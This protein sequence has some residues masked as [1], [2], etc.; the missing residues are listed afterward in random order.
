MD[1]LL[2]SALDK[3]IDAA[4]SVA[5]PGAKAL[6]NLAK[7]AVSWFTSDKEVIENRPAFGDAPDAVMAFVAGLFD[8]AAGAI[9]NPFYKRVVEMARDLVVANVLDRAWDALFGVARAAD[10][11]GTVL[12]TDEACAKLGD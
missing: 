8:R 3:I 11:P 2:K 6:L 5:G 4:I 12:I 1:S 7:W 10:A 9:T